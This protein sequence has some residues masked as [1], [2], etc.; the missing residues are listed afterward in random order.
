MMEFMAYQRTTHEVINR[1]RRWFQNGNVCP[2][3]SVNIVMGVMELVLIT[4]FQ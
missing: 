1:V 3:V 2:C 4:G